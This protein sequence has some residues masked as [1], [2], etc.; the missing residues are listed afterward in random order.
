MRTE[1][2][3]IILLNKYR[4]GNCNSEEIQLLETWLMAI[5]Q[6]RKVE[7]PDRDTVSRL[8]SRIKEDAR[9]QDRDH[10]VR[11]IRRSVFSGRR[12]LAP[13]AACLVGALVICTVLFVQFNTKERMTGELVSQG[14][15]Q[16]LSPGSDKATLTLSTG[17]VVNLEASEQHR[18]ER[19]NG[20]EGA[21]L[22]KGSLQYAAANQRNVDDIDY[23]TLTTPRGGQYQ[24]ILPDGTKA[25]L[26]AAS[27][28][29]YPVA[30]L[31]NERRVE[32]SGEVYFD[33]A[34]QPGKF[35]IVESGLQEIKVLGTQFNVEAYLDEKTMRTT[36]VEGSVEI[37]HRD[38]KK[39][40]RLIPGQQA[41]V[42]DDIQVQSVDPLASIA[43]KN[44]DFFFQK[45]ALGSILRKVSRWYNAEI[46]CPPHLERLRFS[47]MVSRSQ[48]LSAIVQMIESTENVKIKCKGRRIIVTE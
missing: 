20:L 11:T 47:G 19:A 30:F 25:W 21:L 18:L 23:H 2:E 10:D 43:W 3:L 34:K 4:E 15:E 6:H 22:Q 27:S 14:A 26:N 9:Y 39:K 5:S 12:Y 1:E 40:A 32:I 46:E 28:I 33:V 29:T 45:E 8:L 13:I 35:F 38:N 44:G 31:G 7:L 16:D 41:A 48:P 17:R 42:T 37:V 36:L 24:L